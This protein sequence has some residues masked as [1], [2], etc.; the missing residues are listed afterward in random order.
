MVGTRVSKK[1]ES[2]DISRRQ[3]V[4]L[5][6]TGA[7]GAIV[8]K[9]ATSSAPAAAGN[10]IGGIHI[11]VL[12]KGVSPEPLKGFP[13]HWTMTVYGPD[14]ALSGTGWGGALDVK[15]QQ[16]ILN[17]QMT[18]CIFSLTGAV[19]GDVAKVRGLMLFSADR[20]AQGQDVRVEGNLA[21]GFVRV[22][23]TPAN[24][25]FEGTGVVARI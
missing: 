9:V 15:T 20:G 4:A 17:S 8:A 12:T 1:G 24:F 2:M 14:N 18:Q 19:E 22:V 10:R 5:G 21:T 7:A 16:D 11:S 13:H 23:T 25:T 3:L 6:A